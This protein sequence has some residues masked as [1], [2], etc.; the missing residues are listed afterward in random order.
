MYGDEH[1]V[2]IPGGGAVGQVSGDDGHETVYLAISLHN[3]GSGL[4]VI[5]GWRFYPS[6]LVGL[7]AH[8][9]PEEFRMQTRDLYIPVN[10]T[11]FW[12]AAFRDPDEPGYQA[13]LEAVKS[14][15]PVTIDLL[16]GDHEGGQ[17]VVSRFSMTPRKDDE[18]W[19]PSVIRHWNIDRPDPRSNP[20]D[21]QAQPDQ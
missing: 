6:R 19:L 8:P 3:A 21:G 5:H 13:A 12:Q 20:A 9:P 17:R 14:R 18:S 2:Q 11:G 15:A 10:D 7:Q 4:A 1:W 16:Y